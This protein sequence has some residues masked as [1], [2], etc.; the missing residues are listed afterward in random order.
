[1]MNVKNFKLPNLS[2]VGSTKPFTN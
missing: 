1:M 2:K